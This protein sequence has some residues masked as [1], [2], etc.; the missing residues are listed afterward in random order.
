MR[1]D[2]NGISNGILG[3]ENQMVQRIEIYG[4]SAGQKME[5]HAKANA[6]WTDRTGKARQT[7]TGGGEWHG[8]KMRCYV[9]GNMDYSIWL[10]LAN[11]KRYAILHP[12]LLAM[13]GDILEGMRNLLG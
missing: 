12:T 7:I 10:E 11:E 6:P 13:S 4:N 1:W 5:A 9:A 2:L 3:F 8:N